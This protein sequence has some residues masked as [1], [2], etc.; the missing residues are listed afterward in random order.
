MLNHIPNA[1]YLLAYLNAALYISYF[2]L[3]LVGLAELPSKW[4]GSSF[5]LAFVCLIVPLLPIVTLNLRYKF[6]LIQMSDG[7]SKPS[8]FIWSVLSFSMSVMM[9]YAFFVEIK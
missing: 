4:N 9:L 5:E 1:L 2:F 6:N 8:R 7:T 3:W